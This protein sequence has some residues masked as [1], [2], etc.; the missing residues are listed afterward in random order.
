MGMKPY[1]ETLAVGGGGAVVEPYTAGEHNDGEQ[2][3][4]HVK[5]TVEE[6]DG[7]GCRWRG[8]RVQQEPTAPSPATLIPRGR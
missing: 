8:G 6:A 7:E 4:T 3:H 5:E 2:Q 1:L